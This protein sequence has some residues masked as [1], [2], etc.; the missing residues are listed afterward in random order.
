M[1]SAL[2]EAAPYDVVTKPSSDTR[3][4]YAP[5]AKP[6]STNRPSSSV[7][8]DRVRPGIGT[9]GVACTVAPDSG[10]PRPDDS[11]RPR[12]SA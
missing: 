5:A 12:I 8:T 2:A 6:S 10:A 3:N 4:R 7:F 1:G 9:S 11:T